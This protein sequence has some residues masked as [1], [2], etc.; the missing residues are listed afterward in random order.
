MFLGC[1]VLMVLPKP[2]GKNRKNARTPA[3][4]GHGTYPMTIEDGYGR[5]VTLKSAPGR[6]ISLAPSITEILFTIGVQDRLVANTK[7]DKYP[8]QAV[9]LFKIGGMRHP[10]IEM[11]VQL[12][13]S[14]VL[15]TVLSSAT[16]Y[17]RM[18]AAGMT[19]I[20]LEHSDWTGVLRDMRTIGKLVGAPGEALRAIRNLEKKRDQILKKIKPMGQKPAPRVAILYDLDKLYSAGS[21]SWVGDLL[22]LC[23]AENVASGL[24]SAWPQ[25]SLEGFLKSDPEVV[26]LAVAE[27]DSVRREAERAILALKEDP[28]WRQISAVRN[29]RVALVSKSYFDVPGPRMVN[30]LEEIAKAI[31]P[32]VFASH[33]GQ[34][35]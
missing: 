31:Y 30:A 35:P 13:P 21:G 19:A 5:E 32:D 2:F 7:F 17:Q 9:D 15:G 3:V 22:E 1:L 4:G 6:I 8:P 10:N 33:S 18:E 11:M 29:G 26:I 34:T 14:L 28:V 20:A 16:L 24:P 12:R 25:L 27:S 23:H